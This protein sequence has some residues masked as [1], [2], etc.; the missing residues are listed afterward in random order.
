[1]SISEYRSGVESLRYSLFTW[2]IFDISYLPA[3][4]N[5]LLRFLVASF[6]GYFLLRYMPGAET[7]DQPATVL[8][9]VLLALIDS[10]IKPSKVTARVPIT[11]PTLLL[12]MTAINLVVIKVCNR[13]IPGFEMHGWIYP[14]I[15]GFAVAAVS[16]LINRF[17]KAD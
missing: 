5:F 15:A 8:V 3:P 11:T 10:F 4:M 1:M 2:S 7:R 17:V 16:L 12:V 13:Y 6:L 9:A 14:S